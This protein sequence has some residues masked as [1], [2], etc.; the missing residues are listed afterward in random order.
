[1][2]QSYERSRAFPLDTLYEQTLN[3]CEQ[4][5]SITER[6]TSNLEQTRG[7]SDKNLIRYCLYFSNQFLY[8]RSRFYL[9]FT[10]FVTIDKI[11]L[12]II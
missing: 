3:F 6:H 7:K 5:T 12:D 9:V 11:G 10:I 1:M 8:L 2:T 4:S